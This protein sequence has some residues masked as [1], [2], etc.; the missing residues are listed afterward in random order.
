MN[1]ID[2]EKARENQIKDQKKGKKLLLHSCCA[3]CSSGV[4]DRLIDFFEITIYFYNPNM[5][6]LEEFNKRANEQIR[7]I[8]EGY[9]D[10]IKVVV[11]DYNKNE[12]LSAVV[13]YEECLEGGA[14]CEKCFSLRFSKT[15]EYAEKNGFDYIA[16]TLT[17]SPYKNAK[18]INTI[19][20]ELC[21]NSKVDWLFSDF[22]KSN[23]YLNS[24]E[25]SKKFG[26]YRQDY[27]GCEF[28][29]QESIKRKKGG[30]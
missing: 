5:D 26:L 30:I 25:N 20:E 9:G 24:I 17:V 1:K 16:T 12:Y 28:S 18:L 14:R 19:G 3:P 29:L 7:Y 13:G 4:L 6:S 2:Y 15:L 21:K 10:K 23:G 27:C 8:K 11:A 22:K